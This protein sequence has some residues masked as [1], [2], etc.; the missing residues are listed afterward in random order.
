MSIL[1]ADKAECICSSWQEQHAS[2][3]V[4][5]VASLS[6]NQA[7]QNSQKNPQHVLAGKRSGEARRVIRDQATPEKKP[8]TVDEKYNKKNPGC[9]YQG[10]NVHLDVP[11]GAVGYLWKDCFMFS[12]AS[13]KLLIRGSCFPK[14]GNIVLRT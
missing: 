7:C 5:G 4:F 6:E 1:F 9:P 2:T 10:V 13:Y 12:Q 11:W 3:M 14:H 8:R